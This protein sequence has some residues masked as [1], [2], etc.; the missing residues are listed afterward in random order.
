MDLIHDKFIN[1]ENII[2]I[3]TWNYKFY[4]CYNHNYI[5]VVLNLTVFNHFLQN[6]WVVKFILITS[7]L[8]NIYTVY[9]Y[10]VFLCINISLKIF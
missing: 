4:F 6:Y 9:V 8:K 10:Y 7:V 2:K 3:Q 5:L 1:L